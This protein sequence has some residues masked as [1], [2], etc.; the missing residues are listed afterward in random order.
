MYRFSSLS[1]SVLLY[2]T[3]ISLLLV[4]LSYGQAPKPPARITLSQT[5]ALLA[6]D[7]TLSS[8]FKSPNNAIVKI[9]KPVRGGVALHFERADGLKGNFT[10]VG[11]PTVME[12]DFLGR[13]IDLAG[14]VWDKIKSGGGDGSGGS[15]S[16]GGANN[17]NGCVNINFNGSV[18]SGNVIV[19]QGPAC[20]S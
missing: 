2:G 7:T 4:P 10:V 18:G 13:L 16:G 6:K 8:G 1:R 20:R 19:V 11:P 5:K 3:A 15:G 12:Q 14:A 9:T 17:N